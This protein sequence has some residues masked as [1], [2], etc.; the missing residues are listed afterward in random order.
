MLSAKALTLP[1]LRRADGVG[2]IDGLAWSP[3]RFGPIPSKCDAARSGSFYLRTSLVPALPPASTPSS[4]H[5]S[6]Y[7]VH[8]FRFIAVVVVPRCASAGGVRDVCVM[9]VAHIVVRG[10][11]AILVVVPSEVVPLLFA[12]IVNASV[13]QPSVLRFIQAS[14]VS[15]SL[16]FGRQFL[17]GSSC[18]FWTNSRYRM[19]DGALRAAA[20]C[21]SRPPVLSASS[22]KSMSD[23]AEANPT[24]L[25]VW[26]CSGGVATGVTASSAIFSSVVWCLSI[27]ASFIV[28]FSWRGAGL[29]R[30]C[31]V[32]ASVWPV[33]LL[34]NA[35]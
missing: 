2:D 11:D 9:G 7:S 29:R 34:D 1:H 23:S 4:T 10:S 21:L 6:K 19:H 8:R 22:A 33:S 14:S 18:L 30:S 28:T 16:A 13:S 31:R 5:V 12:N 27:P 20:G 25:F 3:S 32:S 15:L 17:L 24:L 26:R 35:I